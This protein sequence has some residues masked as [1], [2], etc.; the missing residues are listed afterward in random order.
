MRDQHLNEVMERLAG[1]FPEFDN[2]TMRMMV[3]L[4]NTYHIL[5]SVMERALTEY[6][7]T[8]QSMDVLIALYVRSGRECLLCELG[9]LLMVSSA[10]ITGLVEGLVRKGLATRK[11]HPADRRK[12]L[13]EITPRG[14]ALAED[15]IPA[16]T[17]FFQDMFAPI[18][19]QDKQRMCELL[20]QLSKL[21][22]PYWEKRLL[23][24]LQRPKSRQGNSAGRE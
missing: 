21:V 9:E 7:I 23:P 20:G 24:I 15:F 5:L 11:E 4:S 19:T 10:N 18:S 2:S 17:H 12:R 16:S 8:P 14:I 3:T 13:A 22:L 6:G 1:Q